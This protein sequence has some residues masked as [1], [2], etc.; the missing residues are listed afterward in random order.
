M[1]ERL[2]AIEIEPSQNATEACARFLDDLRGWIFDCMEKYSAVPPSD[3][4][5]QLTYTTAWEPFLCRTADGKALRFLEDAR[6]AV[7]EHF[8]RK[9]LWRHGYWRMQEA[10]HGTEH[11]ELFL[12]FMARVMPDNA[13]T[14]RQLL[15]A[16]EHLGNWSAAVPPWFDYAEGLYYA[17]YFGADGVRA[18][19]GLGLNMPDHLRCG[20]LLLLA[21]SQSPERKY[22]ELAADYGR[23][24]AEAIVADDNRLPIGL[25]PAG[26]LYDLHGPAEQVYRS[27]AGMAGLLNDDL[28]RAEN[29]LAS[30]GIQFFLGLWRHT[31][32]VVFLRAV[33][34]LL[35]ILTGALTDPDAGPAAAAIG[36]YR[37]VTG[38]R[39]YDAAVMQALGQLSPANISALSM[40]ATI[41]RRGRPP[42]IG[43][44]AD[45]P[46]WLEDGQPRRLNPIL[47]ALAAEITG[48]L[49]LAARALDLGRAYFRLAMTCLPDGREHGCAAG[50]VS[51][52]ARG[53]GRDN[54]AGV[55][56]A[57]LLPL[58]RF[59][60][61][62]PPG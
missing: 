54:N 7:A 22:L 59:F 49:D 48:D 10:H 39:D 24:W 14:R 12:G 8:T 61:L 6:D 62:D 34:R 51:A 18:D 19:G 28:D 25:T 57:V 47:A 32:D 17:L 1:T 58:L 5:D 30:G 20:N 60:R 11:F 53:H 31:G 35:N 26:P 40:D 56:T 9:D 29:I 16:S 50:T 36:D 23:C 52:V 4:H 33:E 21:F 55:T 27:F 13:A 38:K 15:D 46:Q 43:K 37:R 44:R 45:M 41:R 3:G 2:P 42:G